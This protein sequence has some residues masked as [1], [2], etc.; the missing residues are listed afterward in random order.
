MKK[1]KNKNSGKL[2]I[3]PKPNRRE[4]IPEE[5]DDAMLSEFSDE[6]ND[7]FVDESGG[8]EKSAAAGYR[9]Q[10]E[11]R[12]PRDSHHSRRTQEQRKAHKPHKTQEQRKAQEQRKTHESRKTQELHKTHEPHRPNDAHEPKSAPPVRKN[13]KPVS[14][15]RRK[16]RRILSF[17]AIITI[18]IVIGVILSLTVLF[19]TQTY[20]VIGNTL[21]N[22]ADVISVCDIDEGTNIFLAPK[23][24]AAKR[25]KSSFPYYEDVKV[26]F[27]IPDTI[28]IEVTEAIEGYLIKVS[29]KEYL[30]ISTKGRILDRVADKSRY[31][32]PIFI[33]PRLVSGDIGDY[34]EYEDETIVNIIEN[35][36]QVFA[37]NGYQGIT[38]V[39]A[40]NP[41]NI[42]FTYDGRIKV[43][44]G[45]P[46]DISYKI[47]TA[48]TII[49]TKIDV[50]PGSQIRGVLDV[51]H[52]NETKRSYFN[53]NTG[54]DINAT[55]NPSEAGSTP[56]DGGGEWVDN[57]GGEA[58]DNGGE[59]VDDGAVEWQDDGSGGYAEEW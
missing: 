34:V 40:T 44:L 49:E 58:V 3:L 18:V 42:T 47:R 51:S 52:C 26:G 11:S 16:I 39:D 9:G 7:F 6:D 48:M 23:T 54:I 8:Y 41:A 32:L 30:V 27:K 28:K 10:R 53:E 46:E 36:T 35:I 55:E 50:N 31:D 25:I 4:R 13:K 15:L 21:Y 38:E 12:M 1:K 5:N 22:E 37:D 33:G 20:E 57:G 2:N 29:D 14:P 19:K 56:A 43:L 17:I 59:W 45:I 24:P